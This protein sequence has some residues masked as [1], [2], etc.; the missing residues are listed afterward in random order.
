MKEK[1]TGRILKNILFF[2]NIAVAL[3]IIFFSYK[4]IETTFGRKTLAFGF[5][6]L[7]ITTILKIVHAW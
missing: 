5:L 3:L 7:L 6:M 1:T 2:F 4:L